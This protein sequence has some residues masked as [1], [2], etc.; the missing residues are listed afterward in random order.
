M[1]TIT[2]H[3]GKLLR[4]H[5][6]L[7]E[8]NRG[9]LIAL[10]NKRLADT[11][12]LYSQI[13]Q[14]HWNVQGPDFFQLHQLFDQLAEEIFPFVDEI[15]ERVTALGGVASGTARMAA[16]SSGL[17]ENDLGAAEGRKHVDLLVER[18]AYYAAAVRKAIDEADD[19]RDKSTADLF[20]QIS[21]AADKH[22]WFLVAHT[23]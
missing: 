4:S 10:L 15:A 14:S 16:Q 5:N 18:Y 19:H 3:A 22:L 13:K 2:E 1:A 7:P 6:D 23:R 17:R 20:T 21:R 9:A 11:F 12:D 8:G